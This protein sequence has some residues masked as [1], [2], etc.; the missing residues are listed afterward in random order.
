MPAEGFD[1]PNLKTRPDNIT[2][3]LADQCMDIQIGKA[4]A[5]LNHKYRAGGAEVRQAF[6]EGDF[7]SN[8]ME[9]LHWGIPGMREEQV[10]R[11]IAT[12]GLSISELAAGFRYAFG[13]GACG[14]A[15]YL[16]KWALSPENPP[17]RRDVWLSVP[18]A[19]LLAG[20]APQAIFA[21]RAGDPRWTNHPPTSE[22][23][24][25]LDHLHY[26]F[27]PDVLRHAQENWCKRQ[28]IPS[29][30]NGN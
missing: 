21:I 30:I 11:M 4:C 10:E 7:S 8:V 16:N 28:G 25:A 3:S 1:H 23:T 22:V 15:N 9:S 6:K 24:I 29:L 26:C 14:Y 12:S 18:K 13:G 20:D 19:N 2:D 5:G 17:R 27:E